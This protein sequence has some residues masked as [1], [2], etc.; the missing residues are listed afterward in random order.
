MLFRSGIIVFKNPLK[1][2]N[3]DQLIDIIA[4]GLRVL[5][6]GIGIIMIIIAGIIIMTSRGSEEKV[7]KGK[8]IIKWTLIGVAIAVSAS[9][10]IGLIKELLG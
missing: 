10:I 6:I 1:A 7:T 8:K 4:N 2:E 9:F 3:F 5:A